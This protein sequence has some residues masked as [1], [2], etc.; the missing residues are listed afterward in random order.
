M[1]LPQLLTP[2]E[3]SD[4]CQLSL[5][6]LKRMRV[7]GEGPAWVKLGKQIRYHQDS[8][9]EWMKTL[10]GETTGTP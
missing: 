2:T 8:V 3:V 6:T 1:A 5:D 10:H 9:I 4:A 7:R